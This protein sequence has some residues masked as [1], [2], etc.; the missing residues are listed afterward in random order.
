MISQFPHQ[1][2]AKTKATASNGVESHS[3]FE[4]PRDFLHN[5]FVYL[6]MS[7]RAGG[8]SLGITLH[9]VTKCTFDCLYCEID[10]GLPPRAPAFDLDCMGAE[11]RDT[12]KL[13]REGKLKQLPYYADLPSE[14]LEVRHVA[15]SGDGEPTL[16][17]DFLDA[18][19]TVVHVRATDKF[20]KIVLIT[21]S[22]ALD[23]PAVLEGIKLLTKSD[24]IWAKLDGGTQDYLNRVNGVVVPLDK[25]LNNILLIGRRRP[26]VIQSLFPAIDG[27]EPPAR[28]IEE[29]SKRL[30]E[31]KR[32]GAD[33]SL[34]QIYSATRP[35]VRTECS[36]LSLK[37]LSQIAATVRQLT[38]LNVQVF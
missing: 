14:L 22:T 35:M 8:L 4:H 18:I 24:E 38:S 12:L 11:L 16:S 1:F 33:I 2:A 37:T 30:N 3:V 9:P 5:K 31:L 21:N 34:V 20:F 17:R 29:Y 10:R 26:I 27:E 32:A 15:L 36:H 28:E 13:S 7:S 23:H 6:V 25:I 19:R